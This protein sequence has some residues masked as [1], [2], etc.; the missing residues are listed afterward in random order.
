MLEHFSQFPFEVASGLVPTI[1][2]GPPGDPSVDEAW[3]ELMD[4]KHLPNPLS[5][6]LRVIGAQAKAIRFP[7]QRRDSGLLKMSLN[8][9]LARIIRVV[10]LLREQ[11][12]ST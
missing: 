7:L 5:G 12:T 9:H 2:S 10:I 4:G 3:E 6:Q 1:Y 8:K 11:V